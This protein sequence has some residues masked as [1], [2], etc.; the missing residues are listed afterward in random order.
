MSVFASLRAY[1]TYLYDLTFFSS[2][3]CLALFHYGPYFWPRNTFLITLHSFHYSPFAI[4]FRSAFVVLVFRWGAASARA[5]AE[6]RIRPSTTSS[7]SSRTWTTCLITKR[8][9][10]EPRRSELLGLTDSETGKGPRTF[11]KRD[12]FAFCLWVYV[13]QVFLVLCVQNG[14]LCG[15]KP[16]WV[17][18][19]VLVWTFAENGL[20]CAQSVT[21]ISTELQSFTIV[22]SNLF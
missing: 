17:S 22:L 19:I 6:V 8:W 2:F 1:C 16:F 7:H 21:A 12:Q 9:A 20:A 4:D 13:S 18:A 14:F 3:G 11:F 15:P 10:R 5:G